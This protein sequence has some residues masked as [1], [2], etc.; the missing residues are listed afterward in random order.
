MNHRFENV[1]THKPYNGCHDS[2]MQPTATPSTIVLRGGG[3]DTYDDVNNDPT[4]SFIH[5]KTHH[6]DFPTIKALL[7]PRQVSLPHFI[8]FLLIL[9]FSFF[10]LEM[11][12]TIGQPYRNSIQTLLQGSTSR[13]SIHTTSS[14][15]T[16]FNAIEEYVAKL[17]AQGQREILPPKYIP[18]VKSFIG[19][20]LVFSLYLFGTILFP[21]WFLNYHIWL[22]YRPIPT[23]STSTMND[24]VYLGESQ[25][26]PLL[27]KLLRKGKYHH[28]SE[29]TVA[30]V[31]EDNDYY[32]SN[33][34]QRHLH[35]REENKDTVCTGIA[36]LIQPSSK[37]SFLP[38]SHGHSIED[39]I[40]WLY[41]S[42][43]FDINHNPKM[44]TT[45]SSSS[46]HQNNNINTFTSHPLPY[47]FEWDQQRIYVDFHFQSTSSS[48]SSHCSIQYKDG[49]P[50]FY[51]RLYVEDM[52]R[53]C[54]Q[55]LQSKNHHPQRGKE[56]TLV[57]FLPALNHQV[58][59][60]ATQRFGR[61][62]NI[63]LPTPTIR[64]AFL[65]RISSPLS[66]LQ[67]MG[68]LLSALEE[69]FLP[70]VMNIGFIW[71]RHYWGTKQSV[72]AAKELVREVQGDTQEMAQHYVWV[73]RPTRKRH[74]ESKGSIKL[75]RW[76][77]I[78]CSELL[79]GDIFLLP[80]MDEMS[81]DPPTMGTS[82]RELIM[83][84]DA[85]ILGG[86]CLA[87]EAVITG[88]T[89][90]QA[91]VSIEISRGQMQSRFLDI[92]GLDRNSILFAG[93]TIIS[94][95]NDDPTTSYYVS[96]R[97]FHQFKRTDSYPIPC[98][99]LRTGVTSS[100]GEIVRALTKS[101]TVLGT[102]STRDI[103][104]D[105]SRLICSLTACAL[106]A[107]SSLLL[108]SL[109][110]NPTQSVSA[111]RTV[112]QC[113][114][115]VVASIPSDLPLM[116]ASVVQTCS[117][118]LRKES[119]VVCSDTAAL[120]KAAQINTIV[121]DKTGTLTD[122]TQSLRF[123][124]DPPSVRST[125]I[126][127]GM[128][129]PSRGRKR[130]GKSHPM[131]HS[132]LTGCHSL[133]LLKDGKDSYRPIGDPLDIA[134]VRY[135]QYHYTPDH[136]FT[137]KT[138]DDGYTYDP[139]KVLKL[140]QI[141]S[142][143]FDPARRCSSALVLALHHDNQFRLW[144]LIKG[145]AD[146]LM[147][148]MRWKNIHMSHQSFQSWYEATTTKFERLGMRMIA[149]GVRDV[150]SDVRFYGHL[151]PEGLDGLKD[152]QR[153]VSI[154]KESRTRTNDDFDRNLVEKID[155]SLCVEPKAILN[156]F[157]FVGFCCFE[158]A[159]RNS[160][161]RVLAALNG[162]GVRSIICTGDSVEAASSVAKSVGL[163]CQKYT[164][165]LEL[166]QH[167]VRSLH[168]KFSHMHQSGTGHHLI[169]F[170][171]LSLDKLF[172][173]D[174]KFSVCLTGDAFSLVSDIHYKRV[175]TD[176]VT[177]SICSE[178]LKRLPR[179]TI[180]AR[181]SPS[182]KQSFVSSLKKIGCKV[183]M[184][185]DGV[186]DVA[187]LRESD[188]S[189]ALLN[190]YSDLSYLHRDVEDDRRRENWQRSRMGT[191]SSAGQLRF[192][193]SMREFM[194]NSEESQ[195]S[196]IVSAFFYS[197]KKEYNRSKRL[198]D[199]GAKAARVLVEDDLLLTDKVGS[200]TETTDSIKSGE[201]CLAAKFT[202]LRPCIDGVEYIIRHGIAASAFSLTLRSIIF[203]NSLM[204]CFN[205]ATLCRNGFRYGRYMWNAELFIA[206][207]R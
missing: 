126:I 19:V 3:I 193:N 18:S 101:S 88:E 56:D 204:A 190:G 103:E 83:P 155:S 87:R 138:K 81:D 194:E 7:I 51:K 159:V 143:P 59:H 71:F 173:Y 60:I 50:D 84:V 28:T 67:V 200:R 53:P 41:F 80:T 144:V 132:V 118:N 98:L 183:L 25:G 58:L 11:I 55:L 72:F 79:P 147:S 73:L 154:L 24:F 179:V 108:P 57:S 160:S 158:A 134:C 168:W 95:R 206:T 33:F 64:S 199:G 191:S 100:K 104:L 135:C 31:Q 94:S 120:I 8:R 133:T 196:D 185:G 142:F 38:S 141:K 66:I 92:D 140:W 6:N 195:P 167:D 119:D 176:R 106:L 62:N 36:V 150:S 2:L 139:L 127:K 23:S 54:L 90:A 91:K 65:A 49:S 15:R 99:V 17:I 39:K 205:L 201:A 125:G 115:I 202:C 76:T 165:T 107:C 171:R 14:K 63:T 102:V 164:A 21:I 137:F 188:L 85:L 182:I 16:S 123:V 175:L 93:T 69:P 46:T 13:T 152:D 146:I 156:A 128:K 145:S 189:V 112:I 35:P 86:S 37:N 42:E 12:R 10:F 22:Y 162:S 97:L 148:R 1:H 149:M 111:F 30:A 70:M 180:L 47:Y 43:D 109:R 26:D 52:V 122:D 203:L 78:H 153:L 32:R 5:S 4:E 136:T 177:K 89:V 9:P 197:L 157:D 181:A 44:T 29:A 61:Y 74:S 178:I 114:R 82:P 105:S 129:H 75:I 68:R 117:T 163:C 174:N 172:S 161:S 186:N 34:I 48:S 170:K 20:I 96:K 151:F 184:C 121:W 198:R 192:Q 27:M 131:L 45:T 110:K 130:R 207:V 40:T 166:Q 187:A 124:I 169:P 116:I 77:Q 113:T